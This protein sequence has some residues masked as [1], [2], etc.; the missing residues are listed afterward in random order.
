MALKNINEAEF[1]AL[2]RGLAQ[3]VVDAHI[4]WGQLN[5]LQAQLDKWPEVRAEAWAF[6][7][8]TLLAHR[9]TALVS[10]A[11]AFDQED[12]SLHMQSLLIAIRDH[13]HLFDKDGVLQ[14]R[15]D[16]PF[17]Q[18][19]P[20]DAAKPD[21]TQLNQDIDASSMSD[22]DVKALNL[23]R[24]TLLAHRGA[25]LTKRGDETKFPPLF[26]EQVERLLERARTLLNRYNYMFD[27]SHYGM[28]PQG[29]DMLIVYLKGCSAIW[30]GKRLRLSH[31]L[32]H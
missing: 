19:M 13:L 8:Y 6:W 31:S 14:R 5:A 10:L 27:A 18:W 9:Q 24:H 26:D 11:R 1:G 3:D 16:N 22:P 21:L 28:K 30:I 32:R 12:S 23:Y 15:P 2:I 20:Q 7:Y 4:H 29:H 25:T 17:A